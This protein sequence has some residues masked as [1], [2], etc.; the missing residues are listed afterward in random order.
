MLEKRHKKSTLNRQR[1]FVENI[2]GII[3]LPDDFPLRDNYYFL[4]D[5]LMSS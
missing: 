5:K 2:E 3:I 4:F 1:A